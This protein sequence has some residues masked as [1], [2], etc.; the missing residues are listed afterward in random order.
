MR[1]VIF[2]LFLCGC[3]A[4]RKSDVSPTQFWTPTQ[5]EQLRAEEIG[6]QYAV[7]SLHQTRTHVDKMVA[8]SFGVFNRSK[9]KLHIQYWN[10]E[11]FRPNSDGFY[12]AMDGG[13]PEYF[14]VTVDVKTWSVTGHYASDR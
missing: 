12:P 5:V 11:V 8:R 7:D 10:P 14:C 3:A 9:R 1:I 2:M 4:M 6:R 13:F